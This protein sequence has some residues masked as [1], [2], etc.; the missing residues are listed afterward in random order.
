MEK[1]PVCGRNLTG[2]S[3]TFVP[4]DAKQHLKETRRN[5]LTLK[6]DRPVYHHGH[7]VNHKHVN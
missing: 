7:E 5:M 3:T 1:D 6:K 2:K 4:K